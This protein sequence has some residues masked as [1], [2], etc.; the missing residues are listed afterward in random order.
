MR[1][2]N[3][4]VTSGAQK[5]SVRIRPAMSKRLR[6]V[7]GLMSPYLKKWKPT[8]VRGN[9]GWRR[10]CKRIKEKKVFAGGVIAPTSSHNF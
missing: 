1:L 7:D 6:V 5:N 9:E 8:H 2:T 4:F 10:R 3:V